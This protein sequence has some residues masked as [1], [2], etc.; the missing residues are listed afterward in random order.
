MSKA[1]VKVTYTT[2]AVAN[3]DLHAAYEAAVAEFKAA[4]PKEYPNVING[5]GFTTADKITVR[6]PIDTGLILGYFPKATAADVDKAVQAAAKAFDGWR[7][8][9]WQERLAL[10]RKAAALMED[11][12]FEIAA[13]LSLEVGKNRLEAIGEVQET[14]D[15]IYYAGND[16][17]KNNGFIRDLTNE[18][19][20]HH[21][22][23]VLKPFGPWAVI[24]PFNYPAALTGGPAGAA[25]IAG[26]TVVAKPASAT[27]LTA[28]LV[29]K[30]FLDAGLP[31]GV[32]NFISGGGDSVGEAIIHHPDFAGCT[33]TGSSDVGMK[34]VAQFAAGAK[35]PRPCVAEMGGKNATIVTAS[36]DF[37]RAVAGCSRSAFGLGGQKCS[38][39]SRIFVHRSRFVEFIAGM[40]DYAA[41]L[42]VGDPT[43]RATFTGP[44]I[45]KGSVEGFKAAVALAAKE[46]SIVM[47]GNVLTGGIYDKGYFVAPTI[48]TDLPVDHKLSQ[49]E[50]FLP[51]VTV[52][53]YDDIDEAIAAANSVVNGLIAGVFAG[54]AEE[55][56]YILRD[57]D[58]G[59]VYVNKASGATTG[60]WPGYQAFGGWKKSTATNKGAG[61]VYYLTQYLREQSQTIID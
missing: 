42:V 7:K 60:A 61:H 30:C 39:G 55:I 47:G 10:V 17:E 24:S 14:A 51:F 3:E 13:V 16:M 43:E 2:L 29:V 25:L 58:G 8:M 35:W 18:S 26:N 31:P 4:P 56:E 6:S 19:P 57:I 46:G 5:R 44:Q 22:R 12:V 11:R 38:A 50:L 36:A 59:V 52:Y 21:N 1:K 40:K 28:W 48:V 45:S 53:P 23:S 20:K 49:E 33:F 37:E 34:I 9:P 54:T 41:K 32:V 15:L 27:P